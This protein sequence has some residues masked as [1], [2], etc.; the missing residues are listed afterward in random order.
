ML[1][2]VRQ[3]SLLVSSSRVD[4]APHRAA[5]AL[6]FVE[7]M[8]TTGSGKEGQHRDRH[9]P[10]YP[11]R[12]PFGRQRGPVQTRSNTILPSQPVLPQSASLLFPDRGKP[13]AILS[14]K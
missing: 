12:N 10:R 5:P 1:G 11:C 13:V 14:C 3:N 6:V 9:R 7:L 4:H 2:A 8:I